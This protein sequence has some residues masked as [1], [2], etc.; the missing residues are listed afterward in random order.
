MNANKKILHAILPA[1]LMIAAGF[2]A[3]SASAT[4]VNYNGTSILYGNSWDGNPPGQIDDYLKSIAGDDTYTII[5]GIVGET[6][7]WDSKYVHSIIL[8]EFAGY[9]PNTTFGWYNTATYDG[10]TG[11]WGTIFA[12]SDTV[13]DSATFSFLAP[14]SFGFYI[15]PNGDAGNRMFTE[16][17]RNTEGDYQVT[18]FQKNDSNQFILGWEDLD[19]YGSAGGDRDY[20]DMIVK[21]T[22]A[23]PVPEPATMLLFG[24][25]LVGLA[26]AYR[27]KEK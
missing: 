25:G 13:S 3:S 15:D 12:G 4:T 18:I 10:T 27:R 5:N 24:T 2:I 21:V 23:A 6:E 20:Q 1:S 7:T 16:H 11:T 17:L 22:V 8:D 26:G 9:A 19:L 14:T